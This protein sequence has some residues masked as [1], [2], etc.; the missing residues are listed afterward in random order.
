VAQA[1]IGT[2][3]DLATSARNMVDGAIAVTTGRLHLDDPDD[4]FYRVL[5]ND[6]I[7]L[8][9]FRHELAH[10]VAMLLIRMDPRVIAV[11]KEHEL[12]EAEEFGAPYLRFSDPVHLV[13]YSHRETAALRC[14]C[15]ALDGSL[16]DVLSEYC[17]RIAPGLLHID[18]INQAQARRVSASA[19]GFRPPPTMLVS[20]GSEG[21]GNFDETQA[22]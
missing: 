22:L 16:V 21:T 3:E 2:V 12:P 13:V 11:F 17:G 8:E 10:Q 19:G 5:N 7:A 4:A 15:N 9:Y 20:R 14:L 1:I 18:I 6:E